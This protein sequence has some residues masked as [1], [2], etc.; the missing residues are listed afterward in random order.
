ME[1]LVNAIVLRKR[2]LSEGDYLVVFLVPEWG[3]VQAVVRRT[4]SAG[5]IDARFEPFTLGELCL[6]TRRGERIRRVHSFDILRSNAELRTDLDLYCHASYLTELLDLSAMENAEARDEYG[7]L[8]KSFSL[9]QSGGN[10][11]LV[12]RW[13][14][15]RLL[16]LAGVGLD[17]SRCAGCRVEEMDRGTLSLERGGLLCE[18]CSPPNTPVLGP[19]ALTVL[20]RIDGTDDPKLRDIHLPEQ[21]MSE[22]KHSLQTVVTHWLGTEPKSIRFMRTIARTASG[23]G[24]TP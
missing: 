17:L 3:R 5:P 9:L 7:L 1:P 8:L 12:C 11:T 6:Y 23:Q 19:G 24:V 14:E 16:D 20:R 18:G 13:F 2:A 4:S 15:L 22:L 21:T 10:V